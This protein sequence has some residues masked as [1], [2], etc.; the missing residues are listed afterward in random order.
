MGRP[1]YSEIHPLYR[2]HN[3][4]GGEEGV[5]TEERGGGRAHGIQVRNHIRIFFLD[6]WLCN[7]LFSR[8]SRFFSIVQSVWNTGLEKNDNEIGEN[9]IK[10]WVKCFKINHILLG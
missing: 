9:C 2:R 1:D 7:F 3:N 4:G 5:K 10:N 8:F 6:F